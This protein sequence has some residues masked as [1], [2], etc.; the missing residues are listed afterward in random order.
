MAI[1]WE[2]TWTNKRFLVHWKKGNKEK[3]ER[4]RS[5]S[6][7]RE[8]KKRRLTKL[9]RINKNGTDRK[10]ERQTFPFPTRFSLS[11]DSFKRV[12][13][14]APSRLVSYSRDILCLFRFLFYDNSLFKT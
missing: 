10:R 5:R 13:Y 4:S 11:T 1:E 14:I 9:N 2:G 12:E 7:K 8:K 3:E 6:R